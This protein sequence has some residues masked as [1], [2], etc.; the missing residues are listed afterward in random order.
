MIRQLIYLGFVVFIVVWLGLLYYVFVQSDGTKSLTQLEQNIAKNV[1]SKFSRSKGPPVSAVEEQ[2]EEPVA[3]ELEEAPEVA[4]VAL[5]P[6]AEANQRLAK[7]VRKEK[8]VRKPRNSNALPAGSIKGLN[9]ANQ[10]DRYEDQDTLVP[11][12]P[13][14]EIERNLTF[15]LHTLHTRLKALAGPHVDAVDVWEEYLDTT[16]S[17]LM[18]W[19]EQNKHRFPR[20]RND[21]SIFVSLGTYR[22]PYCPM[23]LKSL[24][25]QAKHPERLY[26]GLLQQNCF[27]KKCRTGVLVGGKVE[28]MTTDMNCYTEF[29]NSP[30]G[31]RSNA[32]NTGQIRLFNVN[33]SESLGPYMARYLGAKFYRGEQYYLQIDSHSEF[34]PSWDDKLIKMVDDADALKPVISTYPPDSGHNWRDTIGG[35]VR[36]LSPHFAARASLGLRRQRGLLLAAPTAAVPCP[37]SP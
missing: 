5:D 22:D 25:A 36:R 15:Y 8:R 21:R 29:C 18:V 20:A 23:T 1:Y 14:A 19:D 26:I 33:E 3:E 16:K 12:A 28:D 11:P 32:C 4:A 6:E 17:L 27:E 9:L 31:I 13:L 30:E 10:H 37:Y 7:L 24:Y 35:W 2:E 34:V